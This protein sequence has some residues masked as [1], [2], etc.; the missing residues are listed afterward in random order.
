MGACPGE[1][2]LNRPKQH[3]SGR[4]DVFKQLAQQAA[5]RSKSGV[6]GERNL[7]AASAG[8]AAVF[9]SKSSHW[10]HCRKVRALW[11]C[12]RV[13]RCAAQC[14]VTAVA[15]KM[16]GRGEHHGVF[17][18]PAL[19]MSIKH[20]RVGVGSGG[21]S[22]KWAWQPSTKPCEAVPWL[23]APEH[24]IE[25]RMLMHHLMHYRRVHPLG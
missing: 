1:L 8:A 10:I 22:C 13:T 21:A 11:W 25:W 23:A 18:Q 3:A 2:V 5:P 7:H 12:P 6:C 15:S 4:E 16:H 17:W 24:C 19:H 20:L 14:R 9:G